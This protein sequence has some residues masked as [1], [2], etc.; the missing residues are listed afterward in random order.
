MK[1]LVTGGSGMVGNCIK[2]ECGNHKDDEFIFLSSK[3]G[4]LT[5][6][7]E[8][9]AIFE[10]HR[11]DYVIH[12]AANVGGLYKNMKYRVEMLRDNLLM[13]EYVLEMCN[14]YNVQKGLFCLSTCIFPHDPSK[15]P[16]TEEMMNDS[17][18]H[19]SNAGY[20]FAKRLLEVQC[21]NYNEQFGRKYVCITP[22]NLYGP[23]D[24][25]N[26]EDSHVI[27]GIIHR[28]YLAKNKESN[29]TMYG[30]GSPLRQ[31]LY[32]PDLAQ[33]IL[34]FV[35]DYSGQY[36]NIICCNEETTIKTITEKIHGF[37]SMKG[38][39]VSD[40]SKS[41]GCMRKTVSNERF[42]SIF[43]HFKYTTIDEGLEQTIKWFTEN[44]DTCRK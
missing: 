2:R 23:H 39:I 5:K 28:M 19:P 40:I 12:L 44:Y 4:D 21:S 42:N 35:Y 8:A 1:V 24:N 15:F 43:P 13:N 37:M 31:F 29:F 34:K 18:P 20:A 33:I 22:V 27:P 16:M 6:K 9:I 32:A 30:T 11:P 26:L 10:K 36:T 25:F 17:S 3:D 14:K 38:E 41:D 7:E